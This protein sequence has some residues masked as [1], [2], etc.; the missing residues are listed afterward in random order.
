MTCGRVVIPATPVPKALPCCGYG[1]NPFR[2]KSVYSPV[3]R[4]PAAWKSL[5]PLFTMISAKMVYNVNGEPRAFDN[6]FLA[7]RRRVHL[8]RGFTSPDVVDTD[9]VQ[10][11]PL[12]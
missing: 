10:C 7:P 1:I 11:L 8:F 12:P 4:D 2:K 6:M 9:G 3:F 5:P